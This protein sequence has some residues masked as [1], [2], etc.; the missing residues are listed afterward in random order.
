MAEFKCPKCMAVLGKS[1]PKVCTECGYKFPMVLINIFTGLSLMLVAGLLF[2]TGRGIVRFV[3]R[4]TAES[5]PA[6]AETAPAESGLIE[7]GEQAKES[8]PKCIKS[9]QLMDQ[10][11]GSRSIHVV[12]NRRLSSDE[13]G[14]AI[15]YAHNSTAKF[16]GTSRYSIY[17]DGCTDDVNGM[18]AWA[19]IEGGTLKNVM[20]GILHEDVPAW[21]SMP[22]V[23]A[24]AILGQWLE[25]C[26][27]VQ[28]RRT[29][30]RDGTNYFLI[31]DS[32]KHSAVDKVPLK[33]LSDKR[34]LSTQ[35]PLVYEIGKTGM[36]RVVTSD[37]QPY[38]EWYLPMNV[39]L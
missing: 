28:Q 34:F 16:K 38:S 1:Q 21:Q 29:L 6:I 8:I 17:L 37:G 22:Q 3:G 20:H 27:A 23:K 4:S 9:I 18:W 39:I 26:Q 31:A 32:A 24:D 15:D 11:R 2:Y 19:E 25:D 7:A 5:V 35:D 10:G 12:L 36:L 13:L 14:N 30:V 33:R